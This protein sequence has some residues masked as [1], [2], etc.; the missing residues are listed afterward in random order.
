MET[1]YNLD[2]YSQIDVKN[3]ARV[4]LWY[5]KHFA[6]AIKPYPSLEAA[7]N[8]W[9]TTVTTLEARRDAHGK[10]I[11]YAP[12]G[13]NDLFGMVVIANKAQITQEIYE[14]KS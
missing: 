13:L 8:T 4:H 2:F 7:I 3:Q 10:W 11:V 1:G 12:F 6:Y 9:P 5:E 14:R